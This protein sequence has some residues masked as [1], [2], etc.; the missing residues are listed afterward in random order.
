MI[1][2]E[3]EKNKHP[4]GLYVNTSNQKDE[5]E[6]G[7]QIHETQL[8]KIAAAPVATSGKKKF[9]VDRVR[10][11]RTTFGAAAQEAGLFG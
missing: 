9:S 7:E 1:V 10:E 5:V 3:K 11:R 4:S 6:V 8:R 2:E